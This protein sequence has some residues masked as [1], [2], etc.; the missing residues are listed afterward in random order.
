MVDMNGIVA[1]VRYP[2]KSARGERLD[3]VDVEAGGFAGDRAW[4]CIDERDGTVGSAKHPQLWGRLLDVGTELRDRL[5]LRVD[6]RTVVAGSVEADAALSGLLDRPIRLTREVPADAKLH[7]RLP[8]EEGMVPEW[9]SDVV[10]GQE[11]VTAMSG[12]GRFVDF[13]AVHV[14]TTGALATLSERAGRTSVPI[15]RFRPN[16]VLDAPRDPEPGEELR[17]GDVVLRVITPTPRCIVP[18]LEDGEAAVDRVLLG[19]LARRYRIPV[20][21]LGRAACFGTYAEVVQPGRLRVSVD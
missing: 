19:A 2:L 20:P 17:F 12:G 21:G 8:D 5:E 18:G 10:A 7:R 4:A 1:L 15:H 9:M 6:G 13:G 14:V 16:V 11:T 3:A